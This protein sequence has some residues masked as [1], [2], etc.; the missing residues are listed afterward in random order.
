MDMLADE[1]AIGEM[2]NRQYGAVAAVLV[3]ED[4][5]ASEVSI[6][7]TPKANAV[8]K[9]LNRASVTFVGQIGEDVV[10][11]TGVGDPV[12]PE[13]DAKAGG[14][15]LVGALPHPLH[16]VDLRDTGKV[17]FTRSDDD[18]NPLP[19]TLDE[20]KEMKRAAPTSEQEEA[21]ARRKREDEEAAQKAAEDGEEE[22]DE[23][24]EDE[25]DEDEDGDFEDD[26]AEDD[27]DEEEAQAA[28]LME[29]LGMKVRAKF[30][31]E[32]GREPTDEEFQGLMEVLIG[33]QQGAEGAESD[34]DA[35]EDA[36]EADAPAPK[37]AKVA[38]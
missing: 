32:A 29:V 23:A 14:Q 28:M 13:E 24:E 33:A 34:G 38:E 1:N 12:E 25:E 18:A 5:V 10:C 21:H 11:V 6:D 20:Y 26:G 9:L 35:G 36:A 37:K 2:M 3:G 4:G 8:A 19:F 17:L 31:R 15:S 27:E 7:M 22:E 16:E 30:L